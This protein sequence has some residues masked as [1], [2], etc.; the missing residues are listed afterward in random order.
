MFKEVVINDIC[1]DVEV[2][3]RELAQISSNR[4]LQDNFNVY[5]NF[6]CEDPTT[7][8][9][10]N[11]TSTDPSICTGLMPPELE[12]ELKYFNINIARLVMCTIISILICDNSARTRKLILSII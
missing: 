4:A 2:Q 7:Y 11:V 6:D 10:M 12:G 3:F 5:L 9:F 1:S 8:F